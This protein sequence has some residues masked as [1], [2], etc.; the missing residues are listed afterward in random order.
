M[1]FSEATAKIRKLYH[2][3]VLAHRSDP[4]PLYR[5][6]SDALEHALNVLATDSK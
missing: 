3:Y 2:D 4:I 5:L 6:H 1:K